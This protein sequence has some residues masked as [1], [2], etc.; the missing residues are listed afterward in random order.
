MKETF[1]FSDTRHGDILSTRCGVDV[2][3]TATGTIRFFTFP[4]R[5][6]GPQDLQ[7][8]N[9]KVVA[10]AG[11]NEVR[12]QQAGMTMEHKVEP[13]GTV[14]SIIAARQPV[15]F[16]GVLKTNVD[17]GEVIL[18]SPHSDDIEELCKRLTA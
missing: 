8:F 13:D 12:W 2:T 1:D 14:T 15:H 6:V 3:L 10:T 9:V 18:Q 5:P 7:T 4:N 16:T 11:G 17:T